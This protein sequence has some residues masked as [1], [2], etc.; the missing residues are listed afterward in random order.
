MSI[1]FSVEFFPPSE[2]LFQ[3]TCNTIKEYIQNFPIQRI[4]ITH[5]AAGGKKD[6][7]LAFIN[8]IL[9]NNIIEPQNITAHLSCAGLEKSEVLNYVEKFYNTGIREILVIKGDPTATQVQNGYNN[10]SEAISDIKKQ[11]AQIK[12]VAAC[13]PEPRHGVEDEITILKEK[14]AGGADRFISQFCFENHFFENFYQQIQTNGIFNEITVGLIVPSKQTLGFAQKCYA[15][16]P[17]SVFKLAESE[18][19]SVNFVIKQL[20]FLEK[21]GYNSTHLYSLNKLGFIKVLE[22]YLR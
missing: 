10:T 19:K 21:I 9:E 13:F 1:D 12:I 4:S 16:I 14:I 15:K 17:E 18:E 7:S 5:G 6:K 8:T 22:Q 20:H 3:E 2:E 11:F